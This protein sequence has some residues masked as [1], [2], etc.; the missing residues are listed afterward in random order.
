MSRL[1]TLITAGSIL[2]AGCGKSPEEVASSPQSTDTSTQSTTDQPSPTDVVSQFL[3]QVRR[4]GD[5]SE[6]G[7]LLTTKA[8]SELKRIGR[9]IRPFGAPDAKFQ[10][11]RAQLVPG[12]EGSA[13]VHS[14][15]S[16][17]SGPAG[18]RDSQVVWAV[19]LEPAGWRISGMAIEADPNQEADHLRFREW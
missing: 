11:T 5:N 6:A 10:V 12:E 9:N 8:R 15:W 16:E 2:L 4:G 1:L 19:E 17:P 13:L 14:I 18:S 3:D 7:Q